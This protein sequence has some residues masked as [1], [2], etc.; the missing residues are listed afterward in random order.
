MK[1]SQEEFVRLTM[2]GERC[3]YRLGDRLF[4]GR[5]SHY[6]VNTRRVAILYRDDGSPEYQAINIHY[7]GDLDT[8]PSWCHIRELKFE[9]DQ[10]E[11]KTSPAAE[12]QPES[13]SVAVGVGADEPGKLQDPV[14]VSGGDG[15]T[16]VD[17]PS[18]AANG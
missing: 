4:P 9:P 1:V 3:I 11:G 16:E 8:E 2:V 7:D 17:Q 10:D 14:G 18:P 12:E 13:G 15:A 6:D 5:L